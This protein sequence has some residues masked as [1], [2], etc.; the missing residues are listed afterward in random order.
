[1]DNIKEEKA[2]PNAKGVDKTVKEVE[3]V[4]KEEKEFE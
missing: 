4:K 3:K 2:I 1:M